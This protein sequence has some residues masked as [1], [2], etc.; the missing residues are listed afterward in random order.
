MTKQKKKV[1]SSDSP[2]EMM[3]R[4]F[5]VAEI[6]VQSDSYQKQPSQQ[7]KKCPKTQTS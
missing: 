2:Q 6:I 5:A 4:V 7:Q 1:P 3:K